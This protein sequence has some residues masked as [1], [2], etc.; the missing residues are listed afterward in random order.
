MTD[1]DLSSQNP[2]SVSL[3]PKLDFEQ[4]HRARQDFLGFGRRRK[5]YWILGAAA[6]FVSGPLALRQGSHVLLLAAC[7]IFLYF[8]W[9][10]MFLL[11]FENQ[12]L[13]QT[14]QELGIS[15]TYTFDKKGMHSRSSEGNHTWTWQELAG[16][17]DTGEFLLVALD[18][19]AFLAL[20]RK[21]LPGTA[22][23]ADILTK[24]WGPPH[25]GPLGK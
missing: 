13:Y 1:R 21:D 3:T 5:L 22:Q 2:E 17:Q 16:W 8:T 15:N 11:R 9:G 23:V 12:R 10:R 24:Y 18:R 19:T 4:F 6:L 14:F 20:P 7:L 25:H